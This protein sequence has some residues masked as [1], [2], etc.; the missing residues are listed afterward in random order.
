MTQ[1]LSIKDS[2]YM[3][4]LD[5][6]GFCAA[7]LFTLD[8]IDKIKALYR[9]FA[10]D[11]NVSG[12]IASHSKIGP[13]KN[14]Q[15]SHS[16]R[17]I[18]MPALEQWF[19]GFEFFMGGFMVKEANTPQELAL[20]QDWNILDEE[21]YASYQIWIPVDMSYPAN[22][23]MYVLPGSHRFFHNYR[24]GSYGIPAIDTDEELRPLITDL[25]IPPGSALVFHNSL[26]HASYPNAS[27]QNRISAIISI[28]QKNAPLTYCQKN[29]KDHCTDVYDISPEIFLASLPKLE[30]GGIPAHSPGKSTKPLNPI[31]NKDI[32]SAHLAEKT[33]I[34]LNGNEKQFEPRQMH[35][36]KDR[37]LEMKMQRDG[38]A[39]V[40]F[41]DEKLICN[42]KAIYLDNFSSRQTNTGRFTTMENM[43]PERRRYFHELILTKIKLPLQ[44][45]FQDYQV[46]IA[47]FF[48]KYAL[49]RGDLEWHNDSS[50]LL[51]AHLEPH[52]AI[53]CPLLDVDQHNGA[54]C[55]V[56]KSHK[57]GNA[58]ILSDLP[59]PYADLVNIFEEKKK[60]LQIKA[61]QAVIFDIRLI[62]HATPNNSNEDRICFSLRLTHHKSAYYNL[63]C[64][65]ANK[66]QVSVFKETEDIYLRDDWNTGKKPALKN[67]I[68]E[69]NNP[70]GKL[71]LKKVKLG[72]EKAL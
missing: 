59:W 63:I 7:P 35:I 20:H 3:T 49:S 28:Y 19:S 40:D 22:G 25:I 13:E 52:Y 18:V 14:M 12:L 58:L 30:N 67:K 9:Q 56:E 70:Y 66:N 31:N 17:E 48:T 16:L 42:L 41:I 44:K 2:D 27:D 4:A 64:E 55:V 15:V 33:K 23:G 45:Y 65:S 50:L 47:S 26:F 39:V 46:P 21:L 53:W 57:F 69:I 60:V 10:I 6:M 1:N 11:N 72:L 62:H 38:Y 43:N 68:G 37:G 51:N 29:T 61:G 34:W 8:Q 71:N 24:S 54:L 5:E 32:T 36:L